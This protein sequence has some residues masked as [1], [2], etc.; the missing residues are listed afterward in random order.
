VASTQHQPTIEGSPVSGTVVAQSYPTLRNVF[1]PNL[2][3]VP[4]ERQ[5]QDVTVEISARVGMPT[6]KYSQVQLLSPT[7]VPPGGPVDVLV[8]LRD[9]AGFLV[10]AT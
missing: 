3:Y 10:A 9:G 7:S 8:T 6:A 4:V 5:V 2:I 1:L